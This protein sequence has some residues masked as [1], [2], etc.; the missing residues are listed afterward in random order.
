M[1][2]PIFGIMASTEEGVIGLNNSLPWNYPNELEYYKR[3]TK[4]QNIIMGKTSYEAMPKELLNN[5]SHAIVLSDE[6]LVLNDAQ[7]VYSLEEC[8]NYI[9]KLSIERSV[10]MIG[11]AQTAHSFLERNLLSAFFLTKIHKS[12]FG[13]TYLDLSYFETWSKFVMMTCKEYTIYYL[14]NPN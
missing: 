8:L 3:M 2:R 11:G 14:K 4:D 12:Y 13:D 10:F 6:N 9:K 1:D 5:S 7:V